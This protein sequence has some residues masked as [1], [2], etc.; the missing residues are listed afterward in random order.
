MT[1]LIYGVR[2][3]LSCLLC[4]RVSATVTQTS[5]SVVWA[6]ASIRPEDTDTVIRYVC[7]HC[8][9]RLWVQDAQAVVV[10]RRPLTREELCPRRG[11]PARLGRQV[12]V[13]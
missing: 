10:A 2:A 1:A 6:V 8:G 13:S 5:G 9:G 3:D 7:P 4:S 11:R 12:G